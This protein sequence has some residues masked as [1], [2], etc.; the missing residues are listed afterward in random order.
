MDNDFEQKLNEIMENSKTFD[1]NWFWI[2][3]LFLL[4]G[5]TYN[6]GDD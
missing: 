1:S 6:E 2:V 5:T 4:F 3:L